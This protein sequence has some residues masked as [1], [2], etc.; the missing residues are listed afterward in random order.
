MYNCVYFWLNVTLKTYVVSGNVKNFHQI[1]EKIHF[2][3][4]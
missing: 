1:V 4:R 3:N 2:L